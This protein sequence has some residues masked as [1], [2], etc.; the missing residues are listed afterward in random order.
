MKRAFKYLVIAA[1]N[2]VLLTA[3]LWLWADKLE[4][5]FS[6]WVLVIE[7]LKILGCTVASLIAIRIAVYFLR[8]KNIANNRTRIKVATA[9]TLL[10]SSYLYI[11]YAVNIADHNIT[12]RQFR[13]A[14]AAKTSYD[15]MSREVA[16]LSY[17]E[18]AAI[19]EMT[20]YPAVDSN[21]NN[22]SFAYHYDGFLPDYDFS[23][24]YFLP[25]GSKADTFNRQQ[26]EFSESQTTDTVNGQLKVTYTETEM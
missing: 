23:I 19:R 1:I 10:I 4:V 13:Q 17:K 8:K 12:N 24:S 20:C 15:G 5:L 6:D 18:Y 7:A 25:L 22:I 11:E 3:M 16:N 21:A 9:I 14:I 26:G 2:A